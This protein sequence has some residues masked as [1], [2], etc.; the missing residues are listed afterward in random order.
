MNEKHTVALSKKLSWLLRH[1]AAECGLAIDAA[2][3]VEIDDVLDELKMSREELDRVV[4]QNNKSRFE[5]AGSRIRASQGH[6]TAA[7][8]VAPEALEASW[9]RYEG[10]G[11][12]W[13]GTRV[14]AVASIAQQGI[15]P[16]S[17]TH[18]HLAPSVDSHVG[19]RASVD[20]LLEVSIDALRAHALPV[21]VSPNGVL[22][23]R[24]VPPKAIVGLRA[25]TKAGKKSEAEM[26][27]ALGLS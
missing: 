6:S 13:H 14:E 17:R 7:S 21:F 8:G 24:I 15:L 20:V 1:A 5:L 11:P 2:G 9:A 12:L 4:A 26:K 25:M 22:L 27:R 23:A 10:P 18:V 19:K 16:V 3:W